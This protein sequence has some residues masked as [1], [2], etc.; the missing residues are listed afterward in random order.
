MALE[1]GGLNGRVASQ[2]YEGAHQH[3]RF[4]AVAAE[5]GACHRNAVQFSRELAAS[6]HAPLCRA[7]GNHCHYPPFAKTI[8]VCIWVC[9][10][11]ACCKTICLCIAQCTM[12]FV[13]DEIWLTR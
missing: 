9:Q 8:S 12:C 10:L 3:M 6:Q 4:F 11:G 5:T 13:V 7:Y 1:L 2:H